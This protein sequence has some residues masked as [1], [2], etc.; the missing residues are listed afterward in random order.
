MKTKICVITSSRADYGL[1]KHL[2]N[3]DINGLL[4]NVGVQ[5]LTFGRDLFLFLCYIFF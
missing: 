4:L 3:V 5:T 1:L 2:I